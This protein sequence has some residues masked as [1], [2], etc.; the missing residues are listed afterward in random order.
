M[1]IWPI[2]AFLLATGCAVHQPVSR[3]WRL[4]KQESG[5]LLVP[6]GVAQAKFTV[7]I[8]PGHGT[9]P[10]DVQVKGKRVLIPA[11]GDSQAGRPPGWLVML[12]S[13]GCI[14]P[15]EA[16]KFAE[17][18]P[19]DPD[20]AFHLLHG[21]DIEAPVRL[22]VVSPILRGETVPEAPLEVSGSGNSL[23]LTARAPA[24]QI[25][26]ETALYEVEPKAGG[27][28]FSIAP[29]YA[30]RH[31]PD[32]VERVAQPATNYLQFPPGASFYRLFFKSGQTDYTALVIA[33]STR[34]E[35]EKNVASCDANDRMCVAIPRRVAI[36]Q[37][38]PV[39]VNGAEVMVRWGANVAEAIRNSGEMRPDALLARLHV[40]RPYRGQ[41][42][43]VEFDRT[44]PAILS[45]VLTGGEVISW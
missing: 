19:L 1:R 37:V 18:V 9:C 44:S 16:T 24:N 29:L 15:G 3:N 39:T 22:Q 30:D 40:S 36:N 11:G 8:A 32:K 27:V 17:S 12:E 5:Q 35:L 6:P 2:P 10:P 25:G 28:G 42:R 45:L 34:A 41:P 23:T 33:G 14:A 38:V 7:K 20:V 26:Y 43:P 31:L 21:D 4:L 13:Q